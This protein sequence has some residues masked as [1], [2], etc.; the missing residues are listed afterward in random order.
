M[1][2]AFDTDE[3][4][5]AICLGSLGAAIEIKEM[6]IFVQHEPKRKV[7]NAF[8]AAGET[9]DPK[10]MVRDLDK[11]MATRKIPKSLSLSFANLYAHAKRAKYTVRIGQ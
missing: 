7:L 8:F 6:G 2:T 10:A 1:F 5:K 11:L 3:D 4:G 9:K